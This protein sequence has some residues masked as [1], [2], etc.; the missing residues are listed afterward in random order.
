MEKRGEINAA[1]AKNENTLSSLLNTEQDLLECAAITRDI[2]TL[3]WSIEHEHMPNLET[4]HI[5]EM[6]RIFDIIDNFND[7]VLPQVKDQVRRYEDLIDKLELHHESKNLP[8]SSFF[9]GMWRSGSSSNEN[10]SHISKIDEIQKQLETAQLQSKSHS[11]LLE[12]LYSSRRK[13]SIGKE[14]IED[15]ENSDSEHEYDDR[16]DLI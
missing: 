11:Q 4:R 13:L 5:L 2:A 15:S 3:A 7:I 6:K 1:Y 9:S 8:I 10:E 12:Q 14:I 16:F